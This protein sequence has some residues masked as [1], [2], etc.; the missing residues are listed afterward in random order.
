MEGLGSIKRSGKKSGMA[1]LKGLNSIAKKSKG[2]M[3]QRAK[4]QDMKVKGAKGLTKVSQEYYDEHE[5]NNGE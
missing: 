1:K 5:E 4:A 2:L 3:A